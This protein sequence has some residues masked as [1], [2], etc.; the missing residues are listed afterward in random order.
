MAIEEPRARSLGHRRLGWGMGGG[1]GAALGPESAP[2]APGRADPL[3]AGLGRRR[4]RD[5]SRG[6]KGAG[7]RLGRRPGGRPS[8][9]AGCGAPAALPA[10]QELPPSGAGAAGL[11][12]RW[13]IRAQPGAQPW[14]R[15]VLSASNPKRDLQAASP[16]ALRSPSASP[17]VCRGATPPASLHP[18]RHGWEGLAA[19]PSRPAASPRKSPAAG[20]ARAARGERLSAGGGGLPALPQR[21]GFA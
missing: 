21:F 20:A 4:S 3:G 16:P 10:R 8:L 1:G 19:P 18:G 14:R 12:P 15:S 5:Q 6:D 7:P 11:Q 13:P 17:L 9:G 2:Q